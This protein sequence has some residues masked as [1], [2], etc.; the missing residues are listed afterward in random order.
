MKSPLFPKAEGYLMTLGTNIRLA[1]K[2]RHWTTE[3][4]AERAGISRTTLVAIEKGEPSVSMGHYTSVLF[5]LGLSQDLALVA[6]QDH[7]GRDLQ[8]LETMG[9]DRRKIKSKVKS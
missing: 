4:L 7:L 1:R 9:S 2:R 3:S 6:S 8:D 5:A